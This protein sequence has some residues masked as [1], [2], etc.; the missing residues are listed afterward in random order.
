MKTRFHVMTK[1]SVFL[2]LIVSL[3]LAP[4]LACN[5][6]AAGPTPTPTPVPPTPTP[7]SVP[8]TPTPALVPGIDEPIIVEGINIR[9]LDA[10]TEESLVSHSGTRFPSNPDDIFLVLEFSVSSFEDIDRISRY[11]TLSCGNYEYNAVSNV[12][13]FGDDGRLQPWH[14]IFEVAQDLDFETCVF[15]LNESDIELATFFK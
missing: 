13:S 9:I 1:E 6:G 12:I 5:L 14:L 15:H 7:T 2:F 10:Y 8:P 11:A 3:L 4:S